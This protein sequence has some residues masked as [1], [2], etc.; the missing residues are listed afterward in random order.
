MR[1]DR[2]AGAVQAVGGLGDL[3]GGVE[4]DAEQL[5]EILGLGRLRGQLLERG[6]VLQ[7]VERAD[8]VA[9]G[10]GQ[11]CPDAA[12]MA[13]GAFVSTGMHELDRL[14]D[15]GRLQEA[16]AGGRREPQRRE[17]RTDVHAD[18]FA[19]PGQRLGAVDRSP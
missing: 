11:R 17:D 3:G 16:L 18:Q 15:S 5:L 8:G 7:H 13:L 19:A 14:G 2:R 6:D 9:E 4:L 10:V 12:Q 1:R